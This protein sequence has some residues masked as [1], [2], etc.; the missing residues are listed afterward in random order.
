MP[1]SRSHNPCLSSCVIT[2]TNSPQ[3]DT[4]FVSFRGTRTDL[5]VLFGCLVEAMV[6]GKVAP[7]DD[8]RNVFDYVLER[9]SD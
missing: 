1:D 7:P 2:A 3:H 8:L 4:P 9:M 6:N 5:L